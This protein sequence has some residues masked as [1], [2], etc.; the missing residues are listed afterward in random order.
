MFDHVEQV[1]L[2]SGNI[3]FPTLCAINNFTNNPKVS[4]LFPSFSGYPLPLNYYFNTDKNH[5]YV[6]IP[7]FN[8]PGTLDV[9]IYNTAGYSTLSQKGYLITNRVLP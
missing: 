5:L 8:V 9:I 3:I 6:S 2:S 1:F 4:A 7:S